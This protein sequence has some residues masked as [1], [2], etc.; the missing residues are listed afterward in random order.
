MPYFKN[1]TIL[2]RNFVSDSDEAKNGHPIILTVM[3]RFRPAGFSTKILSALRPRIQ[4]GFP[5]TLNRVKLRRNPPPY[6]GDIYFEKKVRST[7]PDSQQGNIDKERIV[8]RAYDKS[9]DVHAVEVS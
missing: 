7:L 8:D 2:S 1:K 6:N 9:L 4:N 3:I 5:N